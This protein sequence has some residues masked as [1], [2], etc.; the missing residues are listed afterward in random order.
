MYSV[1]FFLIEADLKYLYPL[2]M[3][4]FR[5]AATEALISDRTLQD[6]INYRKGVRGF[7][8]KGIGK[9]CE[10]TAVQSD[11]VVLP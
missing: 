2:R 1:S 8:S 5:Q 4:A 3:C 7:T 10:N 6:L 9:T 11:T